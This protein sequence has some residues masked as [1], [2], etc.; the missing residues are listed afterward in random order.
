MKEKIKKAMIFKEKI[1][2]MI[3]RVKIKAMM[4]IMKIFKC[5]RVIIK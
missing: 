2:K 1:I 3:K 5:C 4:K